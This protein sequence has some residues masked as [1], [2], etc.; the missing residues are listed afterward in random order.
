MSNRFD[1]AIRGAR[2]VDGRNTPAF[3][4]DVGIVDGRIQ[5]VVRIQRH[6]DRLTWNHKFW[7]SPEPASSRKPA[8]LKKANRAEVDWAGWAVDPDCLSDNRKR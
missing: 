3:G 5:A 8:G 2:I 7:R 6:N 1:V 4:A